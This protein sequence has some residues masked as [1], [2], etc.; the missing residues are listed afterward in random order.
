MENRKKKF[1][2]FGNLFQKFESILRRIFLDNGLF[3]YA[4]KVDRN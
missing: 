3:F 2:K 4:L 1:R